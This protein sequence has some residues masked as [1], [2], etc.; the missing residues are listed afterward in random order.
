MAAPKKSENT[1]AAP[2]A[3]EMIPPEPKKEIQL[4]TM[5][6]KG[7]DYVAVH[8]RV[9]YFRGVCKDVN[10][11]H[12]EWEDGKGKN[13]GINV[14]PIHVDREYALMQAE[15][16]DEEGRLMA[17]G[18]AMEVKSDNYKDVNNT[19]YIENCSTSAIGRA[20]GLL[21]IG[22]QDSFASTH[23]MAV[24]GWSAKDAVEAELKS[25]QQEIAALRQQ[26]AATPAASER[27]LITDDWTQYFLQGIQHAKS[28]DEADSLM[29]TFMSC[30]TDTERLSE[31]DPA[32]CDAV[33]KI[34]GTT[35]FNLTLASISAIQKAYAS[36]VARISGSGDKCALLSACVAT[37]DANAVMSAFKDNQFAFA[38]EHHAWVRDQVGLKKWLLA[39]GVAENDI[40]NTF[41]FLAWATVQGEAA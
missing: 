34:K 27:P 10:G 30:G 36:T 25:A 11:E 41:P 14:V 4:P 33:C 16:R 20:L 9:N 3:A 39:R 40:L 12:C 31:E 6:I 22:T 37:N 18:E 26:V 7:K 28:L 17:T 21:G 38:D 13:W 2:V 19:S 15:I 35:P 23:E 5:K 32:F 1:V 8:T 24:A 29:N